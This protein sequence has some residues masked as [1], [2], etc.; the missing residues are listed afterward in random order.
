MAA[1]RKPCYYDFDV[2][3]NL[4]SPP[5]QAQSPRITL[6][7]KSP[8]KVGKQENIP[9][10][11]DPVGNVSLVYKAKRVYYTGAPP[12]PP[13]H[14]DSFIYDWS[15]PESSLEKL[16][17]RRPGLNRT[18][19]G[20]FDQRRRNYVD[21]LRDRKGASSLDLPQNSPTAFE[22]MAR[23]GRYL[24]APKSPCFEISSSP[25]VGHDTR[26]L[27]AHV[28]N[29]E[30]LAGRHEFPSDWW[31]DGRGYENV[32]YTRRKQLNVDVRAMLEAEFFGWNMGQRA[33]YQSTN[34]QHSVKEHR[35]KWSKNLRFCYNEAASKRAFTGR[36]DNQ[37]HT[38]F[39][40][41]EMSSPGPCGST[42]G[43]EIG[44]S[45]LLSQSVSDEIVAPNEVGVFS[46]KLVDRWKGGPGRSKDWRSSRSL[47]SMRK[48]QQA[49]FQLSSS[50]RRLYLNPSKAT[51][52]C[53]AITH[54]PPHIEVPKD[55][56]RQKSTSCQGH[57]SCLKPKSS[58]RATNQMG[59][60]KKTFPLPKSRVRC[61]QWMT[62]P[63]DSLDIEESWR[64]EDRFNADP[65]RS[66]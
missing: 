16:L 17:L 11:Y 21:K 56:L 51:N 40:P 1:A 3:N 36:P 25:Y 37:I 50:K 12:P 35:K 55:M 49:K 14:N 47:K 45:N 48:G 54:L 39:F 64:T 2:S 52:C 18:G 13:S 60:N 65:E 27:W 20:K 57:S 6:P 44:G 62:D 28:R 34:D 46:R 22:G 38:V 24:T 31:P 29:H 4:K 61:E 43:A 9:L 63:I 42:S 19:E 15:W 23:L 10:G 7:S 33:I 58:W 66:K 5:T 32:T 53:L 8:R 41:K 30:G 59:L 26:S